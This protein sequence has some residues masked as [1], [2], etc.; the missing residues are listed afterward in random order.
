[1]QLYTPGGL[2]LLFFSLSCFYYFNQKAHL[3]R[4]QRRERL[5]ELQNKL[6]NILTKESS[7]KT[8]TTL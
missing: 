8:D 5:Q 2:I 6:Q 3:R 1:M 4:E 7:N